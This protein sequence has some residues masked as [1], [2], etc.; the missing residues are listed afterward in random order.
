MSCYDWNKIA[1]ILKYVGK[2]QLYTIISTRTPEAS[3]IFDLY[4]FSFLKEGATID[5]L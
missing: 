1:N 4:Y 5:F 2:Q 3:S